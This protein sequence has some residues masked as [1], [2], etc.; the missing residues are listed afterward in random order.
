MYGELFCQIVFLVKT[1]DQKD[2]LSIIVNLNFRILEV[3]G[4]ICSH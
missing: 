1:H 2:Y 4:S 3:L